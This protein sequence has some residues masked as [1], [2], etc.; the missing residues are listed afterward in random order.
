MSRNPDPAPAASGTGKAELKAS[1]IHPSSWSSSAFGERGGDLPIVWC[2]L[3]PSRATTERPPSAT[4]SGH[5]N[6][7]PSAP[8]CAAGTALLPALPS[9][10]FSAAVAMRQ[11]CVLSSLRLGFEFPQGSLL[12]L[13]AKGRF[14]SRIQRVSFLPFL[15]QGWKHPGQ[16]PDCPYLA[17]FCAAPPSMAS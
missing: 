10:A 6:W 13:R 3:P 9:A 16:Q 12:P 15:Y 14:F 8:P 2:P 1:G 7:A 4:Q 11:S 17:P 5:P